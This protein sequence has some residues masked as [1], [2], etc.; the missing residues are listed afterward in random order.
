MCLLV[1]PKTDEPTT[2]RLGYLEDGTKVR[3]SK[4]TGTII[5][6]P[7][8][9]EKAIEEF[10]RNYKPG[11]LDTLPDKVMEVTYKGEDL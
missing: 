4:K 10:R 1:D 3:V 2:V 11:P 6:L 7:R 9:R 8:L 5:P